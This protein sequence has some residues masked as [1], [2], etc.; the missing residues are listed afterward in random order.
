ML[1]SFEYTSAYFYFFK[2][3]ISLI[4]FFTKIPGSVASLRHLKSEVNSIKSG[5]ECGLML[6]DSSIPVKLGDSIICYKIDLDQK[7]VDWDPGF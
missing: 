5:T 4:F 6:G 2:F 1:T 7:E 3:E